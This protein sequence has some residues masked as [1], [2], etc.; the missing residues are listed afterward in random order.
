[1]E[2]GHSKTHTADLL[3]RDHEMMYVQVP[4]TVEA[5]RAETEKRIL[6]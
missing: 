5:V 3:R 2:Y 4:S 1:M 6:P